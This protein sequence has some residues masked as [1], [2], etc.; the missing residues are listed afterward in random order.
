MKNSLRP[1]KTGFN[2]IDLLVEAWEE[3]KGALC[4]FGEDIFKSEAFNANLP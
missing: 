2:C 3:F 4:S 1:G